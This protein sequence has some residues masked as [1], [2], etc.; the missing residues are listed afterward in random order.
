M[1]L[2]NAS[3]NKK[4]N[5]S[6][7]VIALIGFLDAVF[8]TTKHYTGQ[9]VTCTLTGGCNDVLTSQYAMMLGLPTSLWGA[10]YYFTILLAALLYLNYKNNIISYYL[11]Y[12][13][14]IGLL[15]SAYLVYL[16]LFIIHSI[17]PYCMLSALTSTTL[18]ILS[19][20]N[21]IINKERK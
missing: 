12:V 13:T 21:L 8:L 1:K 9:E 16:Q 11:N 14:I 19:L 15:M 5:Y 20:T 17:C 3:I 2:I 6:V 7:I 10:L 18:F 4:I